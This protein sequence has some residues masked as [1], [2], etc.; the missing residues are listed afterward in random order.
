MKAEELRM[1][2][3]IVAALRVN[4]TAIGSVKIYGR[5]GGVIQN[6]NGEDA[7]LQIY[8]AI[9]S[10]DG[11]I[12]VTGAKKGLAVYGN[13]LRNEAKER[14]G[15]HPEIDRLEKIARSKQAV[16]CDVVRR[17]EARRLPDMRR[18]LRAGL[19]RSHTAQG[20]PA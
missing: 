10:N 6:K 3:E 11:Y 20:R 9:A 5:N 14:P 13:S 8:A 18:Q 2:M 4:P 19:H 16:R 7:P 12:S 15:T 1:F 17:E